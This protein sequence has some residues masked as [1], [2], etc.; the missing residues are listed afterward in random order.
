MIVAMLAKRIFLNDVKT[1]SNL[2]HPSRW[3]QTESH[4]S[5]RWACFALAIFCGSGAISIAKMS[6]VG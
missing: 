5:G 2:T 3:S 6:N 4:A 1:T